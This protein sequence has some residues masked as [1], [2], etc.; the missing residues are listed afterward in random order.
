[1]YGNLSKCG[2]FYLEIK[3]LGHIIID[4]GIAMDLKNIFV[5][6]D[7][8]VPTNLSKFHSFMGLAGHYHRFIKDFSRVAHPINS[9]LWKWQKYA[10][11]N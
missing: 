8:L 2:L 3:Y 9:L 7:W 1:M 4:D 11:S 5:I 6:M 10:W